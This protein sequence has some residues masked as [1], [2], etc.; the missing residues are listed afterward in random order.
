MLTVES[1]RKLFQRK[2]ELPSAREPP[3][4]DAVAGAINVAAPD[5]LKAEQNIA[6]ELRPDLF[7]LICKSND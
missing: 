7:Q 1:T 5:A 6:G 2:L 3:T 4:V